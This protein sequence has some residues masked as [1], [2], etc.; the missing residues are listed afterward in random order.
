MNRVHF[1]ITLLLLGVLQSFATPLTDTIS[2]SMIESSNAENLLE[3]LEIHIPDFS[4][5]L[6]EESGYQTICNSNVTENNTFTLLIDGASIGSSYRNGATLLYD[7]SLLPLVHKILISRSARK[8]YN[9]PGGTIE[10]YL[11]EDSNT[12]IRGT[13]SFKERDNMSYT[14]S[15]GHIWSG[16]KIKIS[17]QGLFTERTGN[18]EHR[19]FGYHR[20]NMY[21]LT[22]EQTELFPVGDTGA[23][24]PSVA[25]HSTPGEGVG[26]VK[27]SLNHLTLHSLFSTHNTPLGSYIVIGNYEKSHKTTQINNSML[28][29]LSYDRRVSPR[30]S[31]STFFAY[32]ST[33][34]EEKTGVV[35]NNAITEHNL[36]L[37]GN[38]N[39]KIKS[40]FLFTTGVNGR[41][42][43]VRKDESELYD[44]REGAL[45]LSMRAESRQNFQSS[46]SLQSTI[47]KRFGFHL[48]P[49]ITFELFPQKR[50]SISATVQSMR[51]LVEG[52]KDMQQPSN[53]HNLF[54]NNWSYQFGHL[55]T[56]SDTA[57]INHTPSLLGNLIP[58]TFADTLKEK[59]KSIR[60]ASRHKIN[61][62]FIIK[63]YISLDQKTDI[64][65]H[66][67]NQRF[68]EGS[69]TTTL[70]TTLSGRFTGNNLVVSLST[71][72]NHYLDF[73]TPHLVIS[74]PEFKPTWNSI[75]QSWVPEIVSEDSHIEDTVGLYQYA[76]K[77]MKA[78]NIPSLMQKLSVSYTPTE[79]L[80]F[81]TNARLFW[82]LKG[83]EGIHNNI[84]SFMQGRELYNLENRPIVKWNAS[85]G[86]RFPLDLYVT[87]GVKNILGAPDSPHS[88]RWTET[89]HAMHAP[90]YNTD[91]RHFSLSLHKKF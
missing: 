68:T 90:Y 26:S 32:N 72:L 86:Y 20:R 2:S 54:I 69:E 79:K 9:T 4:Y 21:D 73:T 55:Y 81:H 25:P 39:R 24:I 40:T 61:K 43:K 74:T 18:K 56:E 89:K 91:Q 58:P 29:R 59:S 88:F 57:I 37:Q 63:S 34:T 36:V 3:L 11:R 5:A 23:L 65:Y 67:G 10:L 44:N 75:S 19:L 76:D 70:T 62:Q 83:R 35:K 66:L 80:T 84:S 33:T 12:K 82:G 85:V 15:G 1:L 42:T 45:W 38:Y 17:L 71:N 30:D 60:V 78:I 22:E 48:T 16:D 77:E 6:S 46:F 52:E 87:L 47:N 49:A 13:T 51:N 53:P 41:F 28:H 8:P 14:F 7:A 50:H 27:L 64:A 31:L